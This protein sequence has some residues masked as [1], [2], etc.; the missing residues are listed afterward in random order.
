MTSN[1]HWPVSPVAKDRHTER[2][3]KRQMTGK[4]FKDL[5]MVHLPTDVVPVHNLTYFTIK[6]II[7]YKLVFTC[8]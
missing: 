1:S 3:V 6:V 5:L 7:G 2:A 8:L 4:D